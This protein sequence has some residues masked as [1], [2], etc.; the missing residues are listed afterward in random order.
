[1]MMF[2]LLRTTRV[3]RIVEDVMHSD[4][5][6][7]KEALRVYEEEFQLHKSFVEAAAEGFPVQMACCLWTD[8]KRREDDSQDGSVPQRNMGPCGE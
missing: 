1:M 8:S 5:T 2:R 7:F 4:N 6:K 3:Q